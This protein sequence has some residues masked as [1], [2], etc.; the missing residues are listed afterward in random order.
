MKAMP[1]DTRADAGRSLGELQGLML[2]KRAPGMQALESPSA[3]TLPSVAA[4]SLD[5]L[6]VEAVAPAPVTEEDLLERLEDLVSERSPHRERSLGEEVESGDIVLL[7]VMGYAHGALIPFSVRADW[8]A[9]VSED[10]LLPGFFE[11]LEGAEVGLSMDVRL[12]LPDSYPVESLR[13]ATARFLVD[14]K[15]AYEPQPVDFDSPDLLSGLGLG[16]TLEETLELIAETLAE[17]REAEAR[18]ELRDRVL[19]ALVERTDVVV[20]ETL[21]D[22]EIRLRWLEQEQPVLASRNFTL[23]EMEEAWQGWRTDAATRL[24]A[25]WRLRGAVALRAII[26]QDDVRPEPEDVE[27]IRDALAERMGASPEELQAQ[28]E[29]NQVL[30]DRFEH[31]VMHG[32]ALDYVLSKVTLVS[33][34]S[35]ALEAEEP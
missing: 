16:N 23:D 2:L 29:S 1:E 3:V 18:R 12:Q 6:Q 35:G 13:G 21:I 34:E 20:P 33:D 22:Q 8:R 5:G 19:D 4:P 27:A 10:P 26:E 32:T 25:E 17:E 15:A 24:D 30:A 9:R 14:V 28:F 11:S 31:L 7:D